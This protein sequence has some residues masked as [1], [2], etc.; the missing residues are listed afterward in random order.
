MKNYTSSLQLYKITSILIS[1]LLYMMM[2]SRRGTMQVVRAFQTVSAGRRSR[3]AVPTQYNFRTAIYTSQNFG[4]PTLF[5][6]TSA[7]SN[8]NSSSIVMDEVQAQQE[9]QLVNRYDHIVDLLIEEEVSEEDKDTNIPVEMLEDNDNLSLENNDGDE[10]SI[11]KPKASLQQKDIRSQLE[12]KLR[13]YRINQSTPLDKPAYTIFTNAALNEICSTLPS[14]NEQ[15]LA[16]KGIGPKKLE[17]FG[18]DILNIVSQYT[19]ELLPTTSPSFPR[20]N[21]KQQLKSAIPRPKPITLDSLTDEQQEAAIQAVKYQKNVFISGAAGTGKSHV[22]K[23]IIQS[24]SSGVGVEVAA[25]GTDENQ[26]ENIEEDIEKKQRKCV[27][28]APTGVAAIN[29]GGSTLHAFFGIGLGTGSTSSLINKVKKNK[30]A[31]KRIDETDVLLIDEVSMLSSD[32]LETID[33]VVREVRNGGKHGDLPMGG[34]QVIAV[35]DFH[36]LPPIVKREYQTPGLDFDEQRRPFCF[37]SYV[38][39]ELELD[40]NTFQLKQALR[41]DSGSKFELFLNMVRVGEVT[42]NIIRDLNEKCLIS[43]E[44]PLPNDG[45]VP[46]RIYTHNRDVDA[47]NQAR[48]DELQGEVVTCTAIDKWKEMMP[49][50]TLAS[51]KKNMKIS[52]AGELP[53]E[54][55]LKVGAQVMLTRNKDMESGDR[56]LV[57]GSR[58]VVE[59]FD[60]DQVPTVRFD[61]GRIEKITRVEAT[62]Y[63]PDGGECYVSLSFESSLHVILRMI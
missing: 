26:E 32:L 25:S 62:R 1:T 4:A 27:P 36:Q 11:P 34:M 13:Q 20:G 55:Q 12:Q 46:T 10:I 28:T 44:H 39:K 61:N 19:G 29:I 21:G 53:D 35:G 51:I 37:D 52:I 31:M 22:S 43:P 16:V 6:A 7:S 57:N 3:Y 14:N 42:S 47:E 9:E 50:G 54:I 59:S 8:S 40:V 5:R 41:Q 17:M 15:L 48:L 49:M 58:G 63:N 23:Y 38:W 60:L 30:G 2:I 24:L 45:I 18:D 33:S 56:S